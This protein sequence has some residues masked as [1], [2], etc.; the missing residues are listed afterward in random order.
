MKAFAA[1]LVL[2]AVAAAV[3]FFVRQRARG[4]SPEM[5]AAK[6]RLHQAQAVLKSAQRTLEAGVKEANRELKAARQ[7]REKAING[8]QKELTALR[9]PKGKRLAYYRGVTVCERWITTPHGEGPI[10]GTHASVDAQASSRITATRLLAIGVFAFAARKK[11]GAVYLSIDNPQLASV[12]ECPQSDNAAARQFA[13]RIM[14]A[15]R[16]AERMAA[17]LPERVDDAEQKVAAAVANN[18]RAE[19]AQANLE[20]VQA[21]ESLLE[22]VQRGTLEV[23]QARREIAALT[24]G[25]LLQDTVE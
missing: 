17:S 5:D 25:P 9:D 11:T 3:A 10:A 12:V 16:E 18:A 2:L 19:A 1:L 6:A 8:V 15:A 14:N 13:V 20:R 7:E 22:P 24:G 4:R 23:D 21:D